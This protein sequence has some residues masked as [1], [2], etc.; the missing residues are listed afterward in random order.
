VVKVAD[1]ELFGPDGTQPPPAP[2]FL[3]DPLAGLVT[4]MLFS[5]TTS[6][7]DVVP[8]FIVDPVAPSATRARRRTAAGPARTTAQPLTAA[9]SP[10]ASA[11]A[12]PLSAKPGIERSR[13]PAT[14]AT[15]IGSQ[16]TTY[17]PARPA[18]PRTSPAGWQDTRPPPARRGT[19]GRPVPPP[20]RQAPVRRQRRAG[21]GCSLVLVV[22]VLLVIAFVVLGFVV[23][24]GTGSGFGG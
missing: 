15:Q 6:V 18:P 22:F 2:P 17:A 23:G 5:D 12:A 1:D 14:R 21:A 9:T 10:A 16:P 24:H 8:T 11:V 20:A 19:P 13:P 7:A 4:G 3:P